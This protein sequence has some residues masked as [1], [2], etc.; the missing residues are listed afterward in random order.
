MITFL[1]AWRTCSY[2]V[3]DD[4]SNTNTV[5]T[6]K[7]SQTMELDWTIYAQLAF[8]SIYYTTDI[9][10]AS[11]PVLMKSWKSFFFFNHGKEK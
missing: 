1:Q 5:D 3:P 7:S 6:V 2:L 11:T 10:T 4:S 9:K 8:M